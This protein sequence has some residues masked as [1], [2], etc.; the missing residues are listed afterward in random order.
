MKKRLFSIAFMFVITLVCTG[1]LMGLSRMSAERIELARQA[2]MQRL[3]LSVLDMPPAAGA[4]DRDVSRRYDESVRK[5]EKDGRTIYLGLSPD[6]KS[7]A[8]YAFEVSG[9]G[10]WG[11]IH[12]MMGVSPDLGRVLGVAFYDHQETPGLGGRIDE[13]WFRRQFAG[14][15]LA[16]GADGV[17]FHF[18]APG[19]HERPTDVDAIT[20]ATE[21]TRRLSRFLNTD[22]TDTLQWLKTNKEALAAAPL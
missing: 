10:F 16:P 21:T 20:G 3:V 1:I 19:M 8:G 22:I 18:V 14:K 6:R 12:G 7:I 13:P 17:F 9:P 4:T 11:P 15:L 2:R 5:T